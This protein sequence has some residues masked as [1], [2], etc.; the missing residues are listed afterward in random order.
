MRFV[1]SSKILDSLLHAAQNDSD[2]DVRRRSFRTIR[3]LGQG[4][5]QAATLVTLHSMDVLIPL[6]TSNSYNR[7]DEEAKNQAIGAFS[8][9]SSSANMDGLPESLL[10]SIASTASSLLLSSCNNTKKYSNNLVATL[11]HLST[12]P[13]NCI[14]MVQDCSNL[15]DALRVVIEEKSSVLEV[16]STLRTLYNLV[17]EKANSIIMGRHE[18]IL[19]VLAKQAS[20]DRWSSVV[21]NCRV[22][23]VQ[24]IVRLSEEPFN[25]PFLAGNSAVL[26]A[27][28]NFALDSPEDSLVKQTVKESLLRLVPD[29]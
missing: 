1:L 24:I 22:L 14:W 11:L 13:K 27:L 23:S 8:S 17:S 16:E 5:P 20:S 26:T 6:A 25:V 28:V 7:R 21:T 12:I 15:L 9:L 4:G 18:Q 19:D 3:Y 29:I 10:R 2:D